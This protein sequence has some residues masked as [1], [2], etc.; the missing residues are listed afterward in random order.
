MGTADIQW[1]KQLTEVEKA[2]DWS[3]KISLKSQFMEALNIREWERALGNLTYN[4][5]IQNISISIGRQ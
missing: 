2:V 1:K 5:Q 4:K 3:R